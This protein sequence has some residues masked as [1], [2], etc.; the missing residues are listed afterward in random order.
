MNTEKK[1]IGASPQLDPSTH[2]ELRIIAAK[3]GMS[4]NRT[5]ERLCDLVS[6][7]VTKEALERQ[8]VE[9]RKQEKGQD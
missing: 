8:I 9:D 6:L 7:N 1:K 2:R 3:H 5:I 4:L